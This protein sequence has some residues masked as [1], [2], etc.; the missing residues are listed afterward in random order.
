M[1]IALFLFVAVWLMLSYLINDRKHLSS[2]ILSIAIFIQAVTLIFISNDFIYGLEF[3]IKYDGA[4]A[5]IMT[6]L[7]TKD[8]SAWKQALI[9]V[10]A[11]T[12]H[13]MILLHLIT[14]SYVMWAISKPFY[15][16]YDELII[17]TVL[18]QIWVSRDGMAK[19][20]DNAFRVLPSM[21]FGFV[22]HRNR[23]NKNL[24][25]SKTGKDKS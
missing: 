25:L 6:M 7:L 2:A 3:A 4:T 20:I 21:L 5:L 13:F 24:P 11:V 9:L 16:I 22:F 14:N 19:G 8:K 15:M 10:F 18:L 1:F 17:M 23:I 12:C